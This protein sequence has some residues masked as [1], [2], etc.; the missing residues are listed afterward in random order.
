MKKQIKKDMNIIDFIRHPLIMN[1]QTMSPS[2]SAFLK[3][4]YGLPLDDVELEIYRCAT[5][6]GTYVPRMQREVTLIGGRRGGKTGKLAA[7]IALYEAWRYRR[8]LRGERRYVMLIAPVIAQAKIAFDFILNDILNSPILRAKIVKVGGN[9]IELKNGIIIGCYACSRIT[10]RGRAAVAI[11]CDEIC[12]WRNELTS[13]NNDEEVLAALRPSMATF[14]TGKII[15][16]S[17]PNVKQGVVYDEFQRR[18]ELDYCVWQLSTKELNPTISVEYLEAERKRSLAN[19]KREF[20]AEFVDSVV[21]WIE[22]EVLARCVIKDRKELPPLPGATYAAAIDPG[23]KKSD[24]AMA[25]AHH[26]GEGL[27]VLDCVPFWTGSKQAPLGF[28][29]VCGQVAGILRQFGINVLQGD[30]F[31]AVAIKQ[32]FLKIGIIYDEFTF[33][34]NTRAQ[35]FSNLRHVIE[36]QRIEL[37]EHPE[38]LQQLRSLEEHRSADGNVDIRP[39]HGQKDDLAVVLALCVFKLSQ[40]VNNPAPTPMSSGHVTRSWEGILP[41]AR[42][43][44]DVFTVCQLDCAKFPKCWDAGHCECCGF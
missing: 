14:P 36:Q 2:Q 33:S 41:N 4:T 19:Y 32:E 16:I 22:P 38:L 42:Q 39:V 26:A 20:L 34:R 5:G 40:R 21:S 24:F 17:T 7:R 6:R 11:I 23:F 12:F 29:W 27:I 9:E 28:Q 31:A 44:W 37:L 43:G 18:A 8:I 3:V 15:K 1:D 25:L 13:T 35:L 10:V 30:Q